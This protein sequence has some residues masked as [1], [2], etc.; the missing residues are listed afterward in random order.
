MHPAPDEENEMQVFAARAQQLDPQ[1]VV[2]ALQGEIDLSNAPAFQEVLTTQI[3]LGARRVVIDL[4]QVTFLDSTA[5]RVLLAGN[6][7]LDGAGGKLAI[8][9]A[10]PRIRKIFTVTGLDEF[11]SFHATVEQALAASDEPSDPVD[12]VA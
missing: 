5:L 8:V 7:E 6:R 4:Q 10:E 2:I 9:C 11:F 12:A 3:E 1:T